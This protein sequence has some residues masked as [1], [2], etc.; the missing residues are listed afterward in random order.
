MAENNITTILEQISQIDFTVENLRQKIA[1][2]LKE[3]ENLVNKKEALQKKI[4]FSISDKTQKQLSID[5]LEKVFPWS[6]KILKCLKEKFNIHNFRPLQRET[7]N[8]TLAKKDCILVMPTGSGKS[9]C[10]QLPA[11]ISNGLTLVRFLSGCVKCSAIFFLN[12]LHNYLM[13]NTLKFNLIFIILI[14]S[15]MIF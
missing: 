7:I 14:N 9:L 5:W 4:D 1:A 13:I 10:F 11:V 8:A 15:G 6:E 2:L 3:R 12:M